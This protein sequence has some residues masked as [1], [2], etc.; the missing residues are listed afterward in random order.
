MLYLLIMYRLSY[1]MMQIRRTSSLQIIFEVEE[2][3]EDLSDMLDLSSRR[4]EQDFSEADAVNSAIA[5]Q[6]PRAPSH[7]AAAER[8][9]QE[10]L[11][12][13][14]EKCDL[15]TSHPIAFQHFEKER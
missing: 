5:V 3:V 12:F 11:V 10:D 4:Q 13:L 2:M 7:V 6:V 15:F 8:A 1:R 9:H 14:R